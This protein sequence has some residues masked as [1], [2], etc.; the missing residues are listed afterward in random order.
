VLAQPKRRRLSIYTLPVVVLIGFLLVAKLAAWQRSDL[1]AELTD[2]IHHGETPEAVDAVLKL[3]ALPHP[4]IPTL[5]SAAAADEHET[6]DAGQVAISRL[7]RKWQRDIETKHRESAAAGE[8]SELAK[9]LAEQLDDFSDTDRP[10]LTETAHKI[11]RLANQLP[12]KTTPLLAIHCDAILM[13]VAIAP[14]EPVAHVNIAR[15]SS[16][17]TGNVAPR[18]PPSTAPPAT[19]NNEARTNGPLDQ[20]K[21]LRANRETSAFSERPGTTTNSEHAADEERTPAASAPLQPDGSASSIWQRDD[22]SAS[23][24]PRPLPAWSKPVFRILPTSPI[25]SEAVGR[26]GLRAA[27]TAPTKSAEKVEPKNGSLTET[28][29]RELLRR[30]LAGEAGPNAEVEQE[31]ARRGFGKLT[32]RLVRQ[33]F[34]DDAEQRM[35]LVDSAIAQPGAGSGAWLLLLADDADSEVRLF[36]VTVM[37]TSND[38]TLVEKAWQVSIRDR[39]P[40]IADLANRLRERRAGTLRR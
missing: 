35:K 38:A 9:A 12:P 11:V 28:D 25:G 32:P 40:R 3:S 21:D 18:E 22:T 31:L 4:P 30:W 26:N 2:C 6:A 37:A 7:L 29:S 19:A 13:H 27:E 20:N 17:G 1:I 5:V 39:D 36:A 10:W 23:R 16:A 14:V 33:Y 24:A 8:L 34:S 15:A